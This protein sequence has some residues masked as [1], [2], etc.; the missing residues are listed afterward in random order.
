MEW[1]PIA[2]TSI[3][4][5]DMGLR[6]KQLEIQQQ[7]RKKKILA[8]RERR[9]RLRAEEL[10]RR[11]EEKQRLLEAKMK[12]GTASNRCT[13]QSIERSGWNTR[14]SIRKGEGTT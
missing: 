3:V 9:K 1:E 7:R 5:K 6:P 13:M 12:D 14:K 11:E 8:E 2:L 10:K 4:I